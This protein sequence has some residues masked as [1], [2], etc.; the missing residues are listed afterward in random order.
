ME[1]DRQTKSKAK[2]RIQKFDNENA[3]NSKQENKMT[4]P[5]QITFY[6][7]ANLAIFALVTR[8]I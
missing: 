7:P 8:E 2:K 6:E 3:A 5:L 4:Y 1:K